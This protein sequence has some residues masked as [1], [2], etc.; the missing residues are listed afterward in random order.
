MRSVYVDA[1]GV[2]RKQLVITESQ[3]PIRDSEK[4]VAP[5][6]KASSVVDLAKAKTVTLQDR[7]RNV[8][9]FHD[10]SKTVN[11][12][13]SSGDDL[14]ITWLVARRKSTNDL[15]A[16]NSVVW[17]V[18]WNATFNAANETATL[19]GPPGAIIARTE[20]EGLIAPIPGGRTALEAIKIDFF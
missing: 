8:V 18:N 15:T 11:L 5:W 13:S 12:Q 19:L 1:T 4:G 9:P 14:F 7:P 2:P 10:R 16:L 6:A 17:N 20:G 3:L